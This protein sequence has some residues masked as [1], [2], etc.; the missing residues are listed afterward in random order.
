MNLWGFLTAAALPLV[1]RVLAGLGVGVLT[2]TGVDTA[3]NSLISQAQSSW[4]GMPADVLGL[5][6]VA[7]IPACLGIVLGAMTARVT[8]WITVA[9][10]KWFVKGV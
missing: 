9:A 1:L 3:L 4:S 10:T 5:A 7:G 8:A 6:G 2:F